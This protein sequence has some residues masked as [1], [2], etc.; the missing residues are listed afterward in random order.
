MQTVTT[1]GLDIAKSVFQVHGIG[2]E[3]EVVI[4]RQLK[5]RHVLV[6]LQKLPPGAGA[7]AGFGAGLGARSLRGTHSLPGLG[8]HPHEPGLILRTK[9][10][11]N[12]VGDRRV[13][14]NAGKLPGRAAGAGA[15][16]GDG[17]AAGDGEGA[18]AGA[19]GSTMLDCSLAYIALPS[20]RP[21]L[22]N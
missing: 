9:L 17:G 12:R 4:R 15:G 18:G 7:A 8:A 13:V 10:V 1:I 2:G 20:S 11:E 14:S 3:G 22:N 6:F 5:R 21:C 19:T 16:A